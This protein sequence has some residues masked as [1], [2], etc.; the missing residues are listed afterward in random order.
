MY[1]IIILINNENYKRTLHDF[2]LNK[3]YK[4]IL[5]LIKF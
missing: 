5:N 2:I 1:P 4:Q 3:V